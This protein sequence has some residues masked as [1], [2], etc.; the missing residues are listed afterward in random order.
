MKKEKMQSRAKMKA[1]LAIVGI[2][3]FV[4]VL[5]ASGA[6]EAEVVISDASAYPT[7]TTS[8]PIK[9]NNAENVGAIVSPKT[10]LY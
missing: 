1:P 4:L 6:S 7:E 3:M 9:I 5:P 2:L 10:L 8:I